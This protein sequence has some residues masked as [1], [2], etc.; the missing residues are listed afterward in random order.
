MRARIN[1]YASTPSG[2]APFFLGV[3]S[4]GRTIGLQFWGDR[5]QLYTC[6]PRR[7]QWGAQDDRVDAGELERSSLYY[8]WISVTLVLWS[9]K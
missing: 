2:V 4:K 9:K 3:I 8:R 1:R 5:I 6:W 7:L